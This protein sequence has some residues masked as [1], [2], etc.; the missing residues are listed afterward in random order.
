MCVPRIKW[1]NVNYAGWPPR[2][3][4]LLKIDHNFGWLKLELG[5]GVNVSWVKWFLWQVVFHIR[6][7]HVLPIGIIA[8]QFEH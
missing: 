4:P 2:T 3:M 1:I 6:D 5:G 8:T 7:L